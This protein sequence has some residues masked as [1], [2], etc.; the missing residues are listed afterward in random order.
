M[1]HPFGSEI[2][3]NENP[4]PSAFEVTGGGEY[5]TFGSLT[6][7]NFFEYSESG[8]T[9][10]IELPDESLFNFSGTGGPVWLGIYNQVGTY[11]VAAYDPST[12]CSK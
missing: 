5:R 10:T 4:L 1:V 9:Y 8:V 3:A 12:G 6:Y 11:S 7:F 2:D